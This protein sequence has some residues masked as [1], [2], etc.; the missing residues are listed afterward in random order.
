MAKRTT[1]KEEG[2][3]VEHESLTMELESPIAQILRRKV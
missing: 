1:A 2:P 3:I